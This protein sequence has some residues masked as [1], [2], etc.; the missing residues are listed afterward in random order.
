MA[1]RMHIKYETMD[2]NSGSPMGGE[3][4]QIKGWRRL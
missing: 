2:E 3:P 4:L 1:K